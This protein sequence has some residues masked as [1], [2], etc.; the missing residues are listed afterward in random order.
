MASLVADSQSEA[1]L[2]IADSV[3]AKVCE[4]SA[5]FGRLGNNTKGNPKILEAK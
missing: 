1:L 5:W 4:K 3:I 2:N